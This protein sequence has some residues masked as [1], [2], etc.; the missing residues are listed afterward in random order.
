MST[1]RNI[2]ALA[3]GRSVEAGVASGAAQA[4]AHQG[5]AGPEWAVGTEAASDLLSRRHFVKIMSASFLLAGVGLTGCRRPVEKIVP[6]S[7][8]PDGYV[9]GV[10]QY[11]ATA[12]PVGEGAV[13][14]LVRSEEGRPIKIEGNSAHPDQPSSNGS[15]GQHM[16]TDA[17]AQAALLGLYDPDRAARCASKGAT[18]TREEAFEFLRKS[19]ER[20]AATGGRRL[21]FLVEG[22]SSPSRARLARLALSLIHI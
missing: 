1:P 9:H 20:F 13:P 14:L 8:L 5:A 6:F 21:C 17:A 11:Y 7:R 18:I 19:G 10:A 2:G 12:M 3:C 16:G 15:G 22:S 4:A